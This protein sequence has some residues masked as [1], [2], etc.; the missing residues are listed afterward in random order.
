L[1]HIKIVEG[2]I[3]DTNVDERAYYLLRSNER[4]KLALPSFGAM[5]TAIQ[6]QRR[7]DNTC[8]SH[9]N[10]RGTSRGEAQST[11]NLGSIRGA[12]LLRHRRPGTAKSLVNT[13]TTAADAI[14]GIYQDMDFSGS[15]WLGPSQEL[16][17]RTSQHRGCR[18]EIFTGMNVG[19]TESI[20]QAVA[21]H[22]YIRLYERRQTYQAQLY[23]ALS[24]TAWRL[25]FEA[26]STQ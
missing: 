17:N 11:D 15:S 23:T 10:T 14:G 13:K 18:I 24:F 8:S 2:L 7:R 22:R 1:N 5:T 3:L 26:P 16:V 21:M 20:R 4:C 6:Q 25:S 19:Q 9:A 12:I